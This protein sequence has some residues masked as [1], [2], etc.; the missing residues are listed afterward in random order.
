MSGEA[1]V[2]VPKAPAFEVYQCPVKAKHAETGRAVPSWT[3]RVDGQESLHFAPTEHA[4]RRVVGRLQQGRS[5]EAFGDTVTAMVGDAAVL[6]TKGGRAK[7]ERAAGEVTTETV[8]TRSGRT[9][10][11]E[12]RPGFVAVLDGQPIAT[13]TSEADA[14]AYAAV[15]AFRTRGKLNPGKWADAEKAFREQ[16]KKDVKVHQ[17]GRRVVAKD[18]DGLLYLTRFDA[19]T[20]DWR[21]K[22]L[23][24]AG[25]ESK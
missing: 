11:K 3:F 17:V 25:G 4:C 8:T 12:R 19:K 1:A 24:E 9:K 16:F 22:P 2:L 15:E 23:A 13:T 6:P 20:G 21:F 18:A 10:V 5:A 7:V 14:R